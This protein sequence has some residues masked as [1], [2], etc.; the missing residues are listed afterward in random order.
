VAIQKFKKQ[1]TNLHTWIATEY[2]VFRLKIA[3]LPSPP[4]HQN[5]YGFG[6]GT[7]S[8]EPRNDDKKMSDLIDLVVTPDIDKQYSI[9]PIDKQNP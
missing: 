4:P 7:L 9:G 2:F 5:R 8:T 6:S 3:S 1:S